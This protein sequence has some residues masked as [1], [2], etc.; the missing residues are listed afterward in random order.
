MA[1]KSKRSLEAQICHDS[2]ASAYVEAM[3]WSST[4]ESDD[5]GGDPLDENYSLE[6]FTIAGL[7]QIIRDCAEFLDMPG[8]DDAIGSDYERAGHDFW[9]TR[10]GHGAGFWDGDWPEPEATLLTDAAHSMGEQWVYV[11]DNGR[12]YIS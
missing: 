9:L 6:D 12:L 4:D 3:L 8:V 1:Q 5:Y 10:N 11:G 2:F 7:G